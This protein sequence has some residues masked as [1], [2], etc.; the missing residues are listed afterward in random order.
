MH[1]YILESQWEIVIFSPD[2]NSRFPCEKKTDS[3]PYNAE[4]ENMEAMGDHP[5]DS[6]PKLS[7]SGQRMSTRNG[8]RNELLAYKFLFAVHR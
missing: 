4:Q 5:S 3:I 2:K 8:W 1:C 7:R 6:P